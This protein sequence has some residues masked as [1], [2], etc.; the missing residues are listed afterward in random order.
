M[1]AIV[2][3]DVDTQVYGTISN[4]YQTKMKMFRNRIA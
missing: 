2:E 1:A 3:T 4:K